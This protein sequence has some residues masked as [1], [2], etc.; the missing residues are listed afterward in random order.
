MCTESLMYFVY[1]FVYFINLYFLLKPTK[2]T[3]YQSVHNWDIHIFHFTSAVINERTSAHT[4]RWITSLVKISFTLKNKTLTFCIFPLLF[5]LFS[6]L[7]RSMSSLFMRLYDGNVCWQC[8]RV[9]WACDYHPL[10][11]KF[12]TDRKF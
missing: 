8:K 10:F 5:I 2:L 1:L 7:L 12:F 6:F 9:L 11:Q 3:L 4:H